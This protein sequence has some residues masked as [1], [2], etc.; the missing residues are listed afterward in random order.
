MKSN[1]VA[2]TSAV[3]LW[4]TMQ[5]ISSSPFHITIMG[6][7]M[8]SWTR[9]TVISLT[10]VVRMGKVERGQLGLT[11][12]SIIPFRNKNKICE[13]GVPKLVYQIIMALIYIV[14]YLLLGTGLNSLLLKTL[15]AS[16]IALQ[17]RFSGS[18]AQKTSDDDVGFKQSLVDLCCVAPCQ[19]F[20]VPQLQGGTELWAEQ[21]L[22]LSCGSWRRS[23]SQAV[24]LF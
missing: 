15:P 24:I 1:L 5:V 2:A 14:F 9:S 22:V 3:N 7:P 12:K 16:V 23:S 4:K 11:I 21:H 6:K 20:L 8:S 17:H 10:K 19:G 13:S 18:L